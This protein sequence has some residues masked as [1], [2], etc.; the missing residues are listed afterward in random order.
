M[1]YISED[2]LTKPEIESKRVKGAVP[3]ATPAW[4]ASEGGDRIHFENWKRFTDNS[5][6]PMPPIGFILQSIGGM[7]Y[8]AKHYKTG[9]TSKLRG[10]L[11]K[12]TNRINY[13]W[14][15]PKGERVSF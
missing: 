12:K 1:R 5:S 11:N 8:L 9:E 6:F 10:V 2:S 7:E 13:G 14:Y 3:V 15:N 4:G